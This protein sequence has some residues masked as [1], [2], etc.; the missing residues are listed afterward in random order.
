MTKPNVGALA[1]LALATLLASLGTS[2]ANVALPALGQTFGAPFQ[3]VQWVVIAYL[4]TITALIAGVGRLGD[5]VGRRRL[6]LIGLALFTLASGLAA[7]APGLDL[8]IAARALQG[9]GAAFLMALPLALIGDMVPKARIGT[10]MGTMGSLSAVGTALGP[11]LGGLLVAG[12]GAQAVFAV[13][14]PAGL[15]AAGLL[16]RFLPGDGPGRGRLRDFDLAGCLILAT[17]LGAYALAMTLGRGHFGPRNLGLLFS[18]GLLLALFLRLEAGRAKPLITPGLLAEPALRAGLGA[19]LI[20]AAVLM[21]TLVVGPFYLVQGLRLDAVTAGLAMSAGPLVSALTGVP[22]GRLVDRL[23]SPRAMTAGLAGIGV[24]TLLLALMPLDFGLAGYVGPLMI[25]TA[26][27]A[28]FQAANNTAVMKGAAADRR[29]LVSG[30]L[31]LARNLGLITGATTMGAVFA[32]AA[33]PDGA[34][35]SDMAFGFRVTFLVAFGLMV[36]A[37]AVTRKGVSSSPA[38]AP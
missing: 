5:L 2:I 25:T 31:N 14:V 4:L 26:S 24:G 29:G 9:F 8:L 27:Y 38:T 10:A 30:L 1:G 33:G 37:L 21:T 7:L 13:M 19:S 12:F 23:G 35:G 15:L 3:R 34:A 36:L 28:T 20:V 16:F 32:A 22:A 6:L 11:S 18:A 17:A